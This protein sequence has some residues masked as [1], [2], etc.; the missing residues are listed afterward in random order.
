MIII[1]IAIAILLAYVVMFALAGFLLLL[2]KLIESI[3]GK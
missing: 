2:N 3:F 1:S